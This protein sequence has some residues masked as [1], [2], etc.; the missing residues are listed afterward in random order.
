MTGITKSRMVVD[1][2]VLPELIDIRYVHTKCGGFD[3]IKLRQ[4]V[5]CRIDY[6]LE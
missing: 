4:Y 3:I 1:V 5:Q 2:N 6:I